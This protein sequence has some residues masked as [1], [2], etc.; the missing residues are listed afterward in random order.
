MIYQKK[1]LTDSDYNDSYSIFSDIR[2]A[3]FKLSDI[4]IKTIY[5]LLK[6]ATS[7]NSIYQKCAFITTNPNDVVNSE[8]INISMKKFSP[9]N[10]QIFSTKEAACQWL[11]INKLE[12][13][14]KKLYL[15][16]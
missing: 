10:I 5:K 15:E 7:K 13:K 3:I 6:K 14:D 9:I 8:L 2:G 11:N 12:S 4:E 16:Y 1:I